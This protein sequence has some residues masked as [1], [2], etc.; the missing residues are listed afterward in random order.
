MFFGQFLCMSPRDLGSCQYHC[1][2]II[3]L[4]SWLSLYLYHADV[5]ESRIILPTCCQ[6]HQLVLVSCHRHHA[7]W[8]LLLVQNFAGFTGIDDPYE[9]PLNCEVHKLSSL[10]KIELVFMRLIYAGYANSIMKIYA[11]NNSLCCYIVTFFVSIR[12]SSD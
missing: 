1:G 3:I 7:D 10:A 9:P 4:C 2:L 8:Y 12:T 5:L 11:H 6:F